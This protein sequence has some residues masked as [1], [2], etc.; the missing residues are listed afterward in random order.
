M[1]FNTI[2]DNTNIDGEQFESNKHEIKYDKINQETLDY[3]YKNGCNT[4]TLEKIM[5]KPI[6]QI[7]NIGNVIN[8]C[9]LAKKLKIKDA[10]ELNEIKPEIITNQD[11]I[12]KIIKSMGLLSYKRAIDYNTWLDIQNIENQYEL[13][14][15]KI[16]IYTNT[17]KHIDSEFLSLSRTFD[18]MT[19]LCKVQTF[20][21]EHKKYTKQ[22][23]LEY[24]KIKSDNTLN[25]ILKE[26]MVELQCDVSR[27][28][29]NGKRD[30]IH[31]NNKLVP[32]IIQ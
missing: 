32:L 12:R 20:I 19:Q 26:C 23:L 18:N 7:S 9:R 17:D 11:N 1:G 3:F 8:S 29:V 28:M 22:E 30:R 15:N 25:K 13:Y 31:T 14:K 16:N 4:Q 5:N 27:I 24:L 2:M 6:Y 10:E 21:K